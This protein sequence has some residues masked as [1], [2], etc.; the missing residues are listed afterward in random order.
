MWVGTDNSY[1]LMTNFLV[2]ILTLAAFS[3]LFPSLWGCSIGGTPQNLISNGSFEG[4]IKGWSIGQNANIVLT[5]GN[6]QS[7]FL[8]KN[9][10]DRNSK[11]RLFPDPFSPDTPVTINGSV[12]IVNPIL[13]KIP[14]SLRTY[15]LKK[16]LGKDT[17]LQVDSNNKKFLDV[18]LEEII[19]NKI[20][21]ILG[22]PII[23]PLADLFSTRIVVNLTSHNGH[24]EIAPNEPNLLTSVDFMDEWKDYRKE[25]YTVLHGLWYRKENA[26]FKA[27]SL[28]EA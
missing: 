17:P 18:S 21:E 23:K 16:S 12:E 3:L 19:P 26:M 7:F 25:H 8:K 27:R 10:L 28:A 13:K 11:I 15:T 22:M 20:F 24:I 4:D 14:A 2:R 9:F 6:P 1:F 5:G